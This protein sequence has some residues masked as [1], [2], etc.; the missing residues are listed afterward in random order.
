MPQP[1]A[2]LRI[3]EE[4]GGRSHLDENG[5][6]VGGPEL[7]AEVAASSASHDLSDKFQAYQ[8]NQ[9]QEYIVWRVFDKAVDWFL[10]QHDSYITN[11]PKDGILQSRIFPGLWLDP[12]ALIRRDMERVL[13]VLREGM[14]VPEYAEFV[15]RIKAKRQ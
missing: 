11:E 15:E 5:Y 4:Y 2:H 12:A 10:L 7:V 1:D 6:L 8:R 13:E 14:A 3:Q 9:V